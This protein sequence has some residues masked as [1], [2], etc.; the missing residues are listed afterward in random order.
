MAAAR[1]APA[2]AQAPDVRSDLCEARFVAYRRV[3][4]KQQGAS[5]LGLEA[6]ERMIGDYVARVRGKVLAAFTEVESGKR[7][8][9]PQLR[10]A[11]AA[12]RKHKATLIVAKLDRLARNVAFVSALMESKVEFKAADF[13]EANRLMIH[14][15]AAVAEYEAKLISDRTK[16]GLESRRQRG[17]TLGTPANLVA[18]KS[19]A[20]EL[21]KA[22][23]R[24][25]AER[26]RPVIDQLRRDGFTSVRALC[27]Q[28]NDRGYVTG[29]GMCW[30]PTTIVRLLAR[31]APA[32]APTQV[33][34]SREA[35]HV[36][37]STSDAMA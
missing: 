2:R 17:F 26:L 3:S 23:A 16:A 20:P 8:D 27:D 6:Q 37:A 19:P 10:K 36:V 12:A 21:N 7:N 33:N 28:L 4:T 29:R 34:S 35:E 30:H 13:P 11:L 18:G 22:K 15:L 24:A 9:R 31:L 1:P 5:G 32:A 25:E 14:I